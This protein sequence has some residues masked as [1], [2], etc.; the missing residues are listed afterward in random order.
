MEVRPGYKL[1]EVGVI[2]EDWAVSTVGNEFDIKLGKMLDSE[3]NVGVP[4][5]Y[6]GNRAVQWGRIDISDLP[7]VPM[8]PT[9]IERFRLQDGD[10]LVCEGG[11]VG[12][13]ALWS[14]PIAECYYQKALHRLRP[15]RGFDSRLMAALLRQWSDSGVLTNYVTQT[16][17]AHLPREKFMGV[18][19]PVPPVAEQRAIATALSDVDALL[20]ALERLIAKK[21]DL[22]QATM[23]QLLTGQTR[24][25]GFHGEWEA[26][27][28]GDI[29]TV[30]HGKSQ[31]D[32]TAPDGKYPIL[33]SGGEIGRT[34]T[35]I[36]DKPSVLIGRKG[37]IDSPQYVDS[38]FWT[39]DTLFFTEISDEADAKFAFYKFTMIRWRSYN[40]A[41]GVPSLNAKTIEN[42]EIHAPPLPEQTAIAAVLSDMDADLA[43]LEQ[44]L[45]KTRALKQGMMQELLTGRTRLI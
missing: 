2:P 14:S 12:R 39:V 41:S 7:T 29:L 26:K 30:R 16:S 31:H 22:K 11:E 8:T 27:R 9:D 37:T 25:P 10:L 13:A 20:D 15:T 21:R 40:E 23:Q 44:R 32:I 6:L 42:I 43:V 38:P 3:K 4:K 24:L 17:I 18:P 33:A 34:N 19:M 36:Y 28:L 35:F 45:A 5:P 1:T